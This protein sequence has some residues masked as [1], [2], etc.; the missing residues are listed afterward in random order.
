MSLSR[1]WEHFKRFPGCHGAARKSSGRLPEGFRTLLGSS[2]RL[3]EASR[4]LLGAKVANSLVFMK[5]PGCCCGA[6][7]DPP[8]LR[9][10]ARWV[11]KHLFLGPNRIENLDSLF[12]YSLATGK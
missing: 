11:V 8:E 2:G 5:V 6:P 1:V 4:W 9:Q 12:G 7:R 10:H 3:L